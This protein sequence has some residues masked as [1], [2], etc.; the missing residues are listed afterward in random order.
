MNTDAFN[1]LCCQYHKC[2]QRGLYRNINSKYWSC[3]GS[4]KEPTVWILAW[5]VYRILA[6]TRIS[7]SWHQAFW[8]SRPEI[9]FSTEP[10]LWQSCNILSDE[11]MF[12]SYKHACPF[13]MC[14]ISH[15]ACCWTVFLVRCI[16]VLWQ[17]RLCNGTVGNAKYIYIYIYI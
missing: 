5:R 2:D 10:L 1:I 17:S 9:F 13:A 3:E 8:G 14:T 7:S 4:C 15:I 12:V 11:R 16:Q 6:E